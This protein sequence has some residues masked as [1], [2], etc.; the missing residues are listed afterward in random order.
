MVGEGTGVHVNPTVDAEEVDVLEPE[1][2][3]SFK[4]PFEVEFVSQ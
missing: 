1:P 3:D 2:S 4:R